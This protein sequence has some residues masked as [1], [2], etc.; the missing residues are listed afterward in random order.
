MHDDRTMDVLVRR[1]LYPEKEEDGD[2][3]QRPQTLSQSKLSSCGNISVLCCQRRALRGY[4][5]QDTH[6]C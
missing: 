6:C 3:A 4:L 2:N 5:R 1:R